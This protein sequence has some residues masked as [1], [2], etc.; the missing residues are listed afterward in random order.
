MNEKDLGTAGDA[1]ARRGEQLGRE[2][3]GE[4]GTEDGEQ[5]IR[6]DGFG[7]V[8]ALLRVAD[9]SFRES[10]LRRLAQ[11]DPELARNLIRSLGRN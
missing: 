6:V 7:Q 8:L 10:L 11:R 3:R 4:S 5:K 1:S 2:L 9:P